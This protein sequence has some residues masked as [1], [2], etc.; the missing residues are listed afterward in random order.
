MLCC[1]EL[2]SCLGP[3]SDLADGSLCSG[4][5]STACGGDG[6]VCCADSTCAGSGSC[7]VV[8]ACVANAATCGGAY[9][10]CTDGACESGG[11]PNK[12]C[13]DDC[14]DGNPNGNG[15]TYDFCTTSGT[16]CNDANKCSA[17]GGAGQPCCEGIVC[18]GEAC[19]DQGPN[20][21]TCVASGGACS[22]A[23][24]VCQGGGCNGGTCGLVG[25]AECIWAGCTGPYTEN[26]NNIC[27]P[28]GGLGQECCDSAS[29]KFCGAPNVCF[30]DGNNKFCEPCGAIG[31]ACCLG[32][33]CPTS[34]SCNNLSS[35]C[36]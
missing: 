24:G 23:D 6:Q 14:C 7:C 12:P 22:G 28:C 19:C 36:Q 26:N 27:E 11:P 20:Q 33:L 4:G 31:Q 21:P 16:V 32:D 8:G 29:G 10:T 5:A 9:G 15:E 3:G 17:C 34:G 2:G 35:T 30:D 13:G 25:Q 1:C 18:D